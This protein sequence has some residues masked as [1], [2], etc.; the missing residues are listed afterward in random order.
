MFWKKKWTDKDRRNYSEFLREHRAKHD[1][2]DRELDAIEPIAVKRGEKF[3]DDVKYWVQ[4][5]DYKTTGLR[6]SS[7]MEYVRERKGNEEAAKFG[8]SCLGKLSADEISKV[9]DFIQ[10]DMVK[11]LGPSLA[12]DA[13]FK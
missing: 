3:K 8:M 2:E 12:E 13:R 9:G 6:I 11:L 10:E 4:Q 1:A 7:G 5:E